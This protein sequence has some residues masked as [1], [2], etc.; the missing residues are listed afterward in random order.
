MAKGN[1]SK[2]RV[3]NQLESVLVQ[4]GFTSSGV[5]PG[6]HVTGFYFNSDSVSGAVRVYWPHIIQIIYK[7]DR[8]NSSLSGKP[9][10]GTIDDAEAFLNLS[11]GDQD[12]T[13]ASKIPVVDSIYRNQNARRSK[14]VNKNN[15]K[16][17]V[18]AVV[19]ADG[20]DT[21]SDNSASPQ[22]S[23][24]IDYA[25]TFGGETHLIPEDVLPSILTQLRSQGAPC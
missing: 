1:G 25:I 22:N 8:T 14:N 13:Q 3:A 9:V 18:S 16:V 5:V 11:M 21:D 10:F 20:D 24:S 12:Y 15:L 7:D 2:L 6:K 19:S 17:P 23:F 4:K